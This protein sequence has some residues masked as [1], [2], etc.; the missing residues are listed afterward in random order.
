MVPLKIATYNMH[1][2]RQ[3]SLQLQDLCKVYDIV[4]IQEHWLAPYNLQDVQDMCP[5]MLCLM[6]SAMNDVI[7]K[8]VLK[9]RPFGGVGILVNN[10]IAT[11][12]KLRCAADRYIIV[13]LQDLVFIN[14]YLPCASVE[15][16]QDELL[17]CLA[18]VC[19][20][21]TTMNYKY[22]VLEG[23]SML[24]LIKLMVCLSA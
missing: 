12:A 22:L 9:G 16:W 6:S 18:A 13:Q 24:T 5:D 7:S 3:G 17:C 1:G 14:V 23:T 20:D 8:G 19:N 10:K 15:N 2:F 11:D 4:F 21:L